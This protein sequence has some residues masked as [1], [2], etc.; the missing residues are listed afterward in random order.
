MIRSQSVVSRILDGSYEEGVLVEHEHAATSFED[1][2][3][4][5]QPSKAT[6]D[7]NHLGHGLK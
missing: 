6:T 1:G 4:S 5:R 3:S 7:D 2:V